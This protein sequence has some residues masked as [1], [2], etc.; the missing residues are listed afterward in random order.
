MKGGNDPMKKNFPDLTGDGKVTQADILKGRGVFQMK[1]DNAPMMRMDPSAM[2][3]MGKPSPVKINTP[4]KHAI[5]AAGHQ[6]V[7]ASGSGE[8]SGSTSEG[9]SSNLGPG[10]GPGKDKQK[11]IQYLQA[12]INSTKEAIAGG[13]DDE[14]HRKQLADARA[15]LAALGGQEQ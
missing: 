12:V 3:A 5:E 4:K 13:F 10:I 8:V 9:Q 2:K 15:E 1:K 14:R 11:R 6:H 7:D